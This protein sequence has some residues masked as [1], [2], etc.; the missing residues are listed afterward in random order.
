MRNIL[1]IFLQYWRSLPLTTYTSPWEREEQKEKNY[2]GG[3]DAYMNVGG[4]AMHGAIAETQRKLF[5]VF[6]VPTVSRRNAYAVRG[7]LPKG[8][9]RGSMG[10][11]PIYDL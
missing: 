11:R 3:A 5:L 8:L 9:P 7:K 2:R 6:L 4:R 10:A 1:G